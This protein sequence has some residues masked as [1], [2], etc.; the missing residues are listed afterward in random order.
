MEIEIIERRDGE[1]PIVNSEINF[2]EYPVQ[3]Y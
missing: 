1:E 2:E 3:V